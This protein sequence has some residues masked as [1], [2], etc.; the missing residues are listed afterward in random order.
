MYLFLVSGFVNY[1]LVVDQSG[2]QADVFT[3]VNIIDRD[4]SVVN[5]TKGNSAQLS[6]QNVKLWWPF[7]MSNETSAYL[8]TLEVSKL[9]PVK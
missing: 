4:G 6:I 2:Q 9:S 8:Y 7:T 5:T 3:K 1:S